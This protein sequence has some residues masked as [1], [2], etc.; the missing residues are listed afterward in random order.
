MEEVRV[1]IVGCGLIGGK[2]AKS[3]AALGHTVVAV[4]DAV[5]ERAAAL[6]NQ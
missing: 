5:P 2:R 1:A 4:A 3:V 6:A